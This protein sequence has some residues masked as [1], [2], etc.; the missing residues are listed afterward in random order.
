MGLKFGVYV[1]VSEIDV[2]VLLLVYVLWSDVCEIV[3][4]GVFLDNVIGFKEVVC[5]FV[6]G[7][8]VEILVEFVV[9]IDVVICDE[10]VFFVVILI[11]CRWCVFFFFVVLNGLVVYVFGFLVNFLLFFFISE[12]LNNVV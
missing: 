2:V 4:R 3:V 11:W 1:C 9:V 8:N 10:V 12:F 6:N 7:E 5:N